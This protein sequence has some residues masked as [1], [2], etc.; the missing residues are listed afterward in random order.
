M[1]CFSSQ[2]VGAV[3]VMGTEG[4]AHVTGFADIREAWVAVASEDGRI[5]AWNEA[6]ERLGIQ[7]T[8]R[9]VPLAQVLPI[10]EER[11]GQTPV[12]YLGRLWRIFH[13]TDPASGN[14]VYLFHEDVAPDPHL[15][16]RVLASLQHT[17]EHVSPLTLE[18]WW[19]RMAAWAQALFPKDGLGIWVRSEQREWSH[20]ADPVP[21]TTAETFLRRVQT[22]LHVPHSFALEHGVGVVFP[23]H[24]YTNLSLGL[25][26]PETQATPAHLSTWLEVA[27]WI[28]TTHA[29]AT[30]V[31]SIRRLEHLLT[32]VASIVKTVHRA[33]LEI[34]WDHIAQQMC[35]AFDADAAYLLRWDAQRNVPVPV[36]AVG[37]LAQRYASLSV[38]PRRRTLTASV[39]NANRVIAVEDILDSPFIELDVA[40]LFPQRS[41]L[42]MPLIHE[43]QRLGAILLAWDEPRTFS[44][45]TLQEADIVRHALSFFLHRALMEQEVQRRVSELETVHSAHGVIATTLDLDEAVCQILEQVQQLVPAHVCM[46]LLEDESVANQRVLRLLA[47]LGEGAP[48]AGQ[49]YPV[50]PYPLLQSIL[51]DGVPITH[52]THEGRGRGE[53][54]PWPDA[55]SWLGVPLI[56]E[57]YVRGV[58]A[59][60][61]RDAF[62]FSSAH[63]RML[64]TFARQAAT[65]LEN[66]R[67]YS[68]LRRRAD[69]LERLYRA[70]EDLVAK[71]AP[72]EILQRLAHHLIETVHC[73]S[74]HIG[75]L[76]GTSIHLI[77]EVARD[78]FQ[79]KTSLLG[80]TFPLAELPLLQHTVET[81]TI[82]VVS[83][84]DKTLSP[85][86][87]RAFE[88]F[89]VK[90]ALLVPVWG[91]EQPLGVAVLHFIEPPSHLNND[92]LSLLRSL[93]NYTGVVLT[94]VRYYEQEQ[95]R[96]Q[97]L[98][99]L[100]KATASLLGTL[101][102]DELLDEILG[103]AMRAIPNA[104]KGTL[105][106][107][108]EDG[109]LRVRAVRGYEDTAVQNMVLPETGY[110][111]KSAR[112]VLSLLVEDVDAV[113]DIFYDGDVPE[114]Q[115]IKSGIV[116]PLVYGDRVYGIISLDAT[117]PAAF[118]RDDLDMLR[119]FAITAT[120]AIHNALLYADAHQMALTD[121]LTQVWNRRGFFEIAK[122]EF[123]RAQRYGRPLSLFMLD[124]DYFKLVNDTYGHF[125]GDQVLARFAHTI[126][127]HVREV[128]IVGRYGGEE[129]MVL[130]PEASFD[131]AVRAA[132][133][134]RAAIERTRFETDVGGIWVTASI[135]VATLRADDRTFEDLLRR[136]DAALYVAKEEGRN[137]VAWSE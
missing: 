136:A 75:V 91:Q 8:H 74:C 96:A 119:T 54:L 125:V 101:D 113:E 46:L 58:L 43:E 69:M 128:D 57:G 22:G 66:A 45:A 31:S 53:A 86:E 15:F 85:R 104:E 23:H 106:L 34:V 3:E 134:I 32:D 137:R 62:A 90:H 7:A 56:L 118:S 12:A 71:R 37:P 25:L 42:G 63:V 103:A 124:L 99:A 33:P 5:V 93:A 114:V 81:F 87:R 88:R 84:G 4:E 133:R 108:D 38:T 48:P 27:R 135:G 20:I 60:Y 112:D 98:E 55:H 94:N 83:F 121:D 59:V 39:L 65:V 107:K 97:Q 127:S 120:A 28:Q 132:E 131:Q 95:R 73:V 40:L 14:V 50:D 18:I 61:R 19:A 126:A 24:G 123:R 6:A 100:Y 70:A 68:E 129:F 78:G 26:L 2:N 16:T 11:N 30:S 49:R 109:H 72:H 41:L 79:P 35:H 21:Q 44:A 29:L 122:R 17:L 76:E 130:M 1:P 77:A 105:A 64:T 82:R 80:R 47:T 102:L 89:G 9:G 117:R 36:A 92:A 13:T 10:V 111:A 116:V 52:A 110:A 67:L 51:Q 115:A